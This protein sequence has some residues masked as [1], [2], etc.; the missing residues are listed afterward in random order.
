MIGQQ[1][2]QATFPLEAAVAEESR[3]P[4]DTGFTSATHIG[5]SPRWVQYSGVSVTARAVAEVL[6]DVTT[7]NTHGDQ[8]LRLDREFLA[9]AV[10][11]GRADKLAPFL[12]ELEAIGFLTIFSGGLD[13]ATGKRRQLRDRH[14]RPVQDRFFISLD[15]PAGYVGPSHLNKMYA[16]FIGDRDAAYQAAQDA[17]KRKR[18]SNTTIRRSSV[19]RLE[20]VQVSTDPGFRGQPNRTDPGIRGQA[21]F[22][23]V[24][25]DPAIRGQLSQ[26]DPGL[27]GQ[28]ESSQ[29][30]TDTGTQGHL[31]IDLRSSISER[32]IEGSEPVAGG[33][34][35]PPAAGKDEALV[36]AVRELVRQLDWREWAKRNRK[37]FSLRMSDADTVQAA[38]VAA[39]ER[40][41]VSLE[42]AAE[43]A[44]QALSEAAG[45][46]VMFVAGA[47]KAPQLARR[48]RALEAEP[49]SDDPLPLPDT[50]ARE[51]AAAA[52]PTAAGQRLV[53]VLPACGT[54]DAREGEPLGWR[55]VQCPEQEREIPCPDCG[56]TA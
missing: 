34:A 53:E 25:T 40:G 5:L 18:G 29:V 49:L 1:G 19:G 14:G 46:P 44:V 3:Q 51:P 36:A 4:F 21:K 20:E 31:Q 54:C 45:N 43:V 11:I 2:T 27:R 24:S 50:G 17:G 47:F 23:Q 56:P 55:T 33:T 35:K 39:I 13:P 52:K 7:M 48:L 22:P 6:T 42:Q 16:Q 41:Q 9:Y 37:T 26:P 32:E 28:A 15:P 10:D 8:A 30:S 12:A 38:V